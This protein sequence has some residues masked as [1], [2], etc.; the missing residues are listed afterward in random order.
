MSANSNTFARTLA[1]KPV[2]PAISGACR[3]CRCELLRGG[4]VVLMRERSRM[5]RIMTEVPAQRPE[6]ALLERAR[7]R[8]EPRLSGRA[9]ALAAGISE[10]RW[11]QI[12][13]GYMSA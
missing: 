5:F 2:I 3:A 1:N 9:A 7:E 4:S 6:G 8:Q 10:G 12:V 13:N 11:R